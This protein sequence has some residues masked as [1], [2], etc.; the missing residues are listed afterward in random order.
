MLPHVSLHFFKQANLKWGEGRG[1][2]MK[3]GDRGKL[4][5]SGGHEMGEWQLL[6]DACAELLLAEC[7]SK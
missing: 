6:P 4:T 1:G 2:N 7:G 3:R 5:V